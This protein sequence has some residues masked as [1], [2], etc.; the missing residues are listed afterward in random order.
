MTAIN[1]GVLNGNM[2]DWRASEA[3][4]TLL[5]VTHGNWRYTYIYYVC[6]TL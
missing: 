1:N 2:G 4:E 3:S 5:G 6:E